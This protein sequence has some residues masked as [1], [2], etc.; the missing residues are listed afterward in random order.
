MFS[1]NK[2][3]SPKVSTDKTGNILGAKNGNTYPAKVSIARSI[4]K[5]YTILLIQDSFFINDNWLID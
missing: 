3:G 1:I 5:K 4:L 2:S